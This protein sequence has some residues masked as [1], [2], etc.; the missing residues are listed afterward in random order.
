MNKKL[1]ELMDK[2]ISELQR[3]NEIT[4]DMLYEDIDG[5]GQ[6]IEEREKIVANVEG[7][8]V[9]IKQYIS[10][11][12]MEHQAQIKALFKFEDIGEI[13][14]D[15]AKLQDKIFEQHQLKELIKENDGSVVGRLKAMQS[16]LIAEMGAASKAKKVADYFSQTSIDLSKGSRFNTSN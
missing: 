5:V 13:N 10:E 2:K 15:L 8:S 6:I 11:Q 14:D 16:E 3:F 1:I 9:E 12:S 7:I 4:N